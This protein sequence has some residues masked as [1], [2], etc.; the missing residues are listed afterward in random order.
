ME[1]MILAAG[2]GTRLLPLTLGRPK[3]LF[4]ILNEPLL[5]LTFDYL[6]R[7]SLSS[8]FLNTHHLAPRIEEF[9][10]SEKEC[11]PFQIHT[12]YEPEIL[13]TGGGI[14]ST[15]GFWKES[16]FV[17]FNGDIVTDIDLQK[18]LDF[19]Q[20]GPGPVTLIL[21]DY[22]EF[23][24]ISVDGSGRIRDF[25]QERGKGLAFTGIHILG[26]EIFD[27]LPS[28]GSYDIIPVYQQ[29]IQEGVPVRAF[30]SRGHYWRDIG[31]PKSYLKIHE[32]ML[33]EQ[34]FFETSTH[35]N[36]IEF[37]SPSIPRF[38]RGTPSKAP[39]FIKGGPGGILIHPETRIETEVEFSGW[40]CIGKGCLLKK[41]CWIHNSVLWEDV[42]VE[43]GVSVSESIIGDGVQIIQDAQRGTFI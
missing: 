32:E 9:V 22:F 17:V 39:P 10:Q 2:K 41:G 28:T 36:R 34:A 21:H 29:M 23:N 25:R 26:K 15:R 37:K 16:P 1:A 30:I 8:V 4:P 33:T 6:N 11:R 38:Q 13:G 5:H 35:Q 27:F 19:H 12:R 24:Q 20:S 42:I 18:A 7:F 31:T 3:P 14:G 43:K 40:A